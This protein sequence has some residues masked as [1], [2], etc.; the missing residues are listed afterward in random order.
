MMRS[1][2]MRTRPPGKRGG[3]ERV[4]KHGSPSGTS[5]SSG[6]DIARHWRD[7]PPARRLTCWTTCAGIT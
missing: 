5:G 4:L 2:S 7:N 3:L 6:I 1:D